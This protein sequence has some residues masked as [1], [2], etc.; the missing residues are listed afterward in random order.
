MKL[1]D[2]MGLSEMLTQLDPNYASKHVSRFW[3]KS[4]EDSKNSK[5][6][7]YKKRKVKRKHKKVKK[8]KA[9]D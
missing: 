3:I 6:F 5:S 8:E 1:K 4:K 7:K 9:E 2:A